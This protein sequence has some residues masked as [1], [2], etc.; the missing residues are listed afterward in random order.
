MLAAGF[1]AE[2]W[3]VGVWGPAGISHCI[4][5]SG[6]LCKFYANTG[7]KLPIQRQPIYQYKKQANTL[8]SIHNYT[9]IGIRGNDKNKQ[10][11]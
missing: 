5:L 3:S 8:L 10:L 6:E 4:P 2:Y 11:T 1:L 7:G 9:P